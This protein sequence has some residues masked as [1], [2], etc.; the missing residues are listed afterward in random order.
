[1][2]ASGCFALLLVLVVL[3]GS[4]ETRAQFLDPQFGWATG[5]DSSY[6]D[7]HLSLFVTYRSFLIFSAGNAYDQS[8]YLYI[9]DTRS[10]GAPPTVRNYAFPNAANRSMTVLNDQ[11]YIWGGQNA[12][13]SSSS[14]VYVV[15]LSPTYGFPLT[16]YDYDTI[17]PDAFF[18]E[19]PEAHVMAAWPEAQRLYFYG[20]FTSS[21]ASSIGAAVP[22]F[23]LS[24]ASEEE[25]S[26]GWQPVSSAQ[27]YGPPALKHHSGCVRRTRE[28]TLLWYIFGGAVWSVE[29][30]MQ[31]PLDDLWVLNFATE[32]WTQVFKTGAETAWPAAR[33]MHAAV[34]SPDNLHM[35]VHGGRDVSQ[36]FGDL[37]GFD[38]DTESWTYIS[39]AY[40]T[41]GHHLAATIQEPY[42]G[43]SFVQLHLFYPD[44]S[45]AAIY[46][47]SGVT[48]YSCDDAVV[49]PEDD[50]NNNGLGDFCE[51]NMYLS[52][53]D[54]NYN[55]ILDACELD[56]TSTD[57]DHNGMLDE[58]QPFQVI[59][60]RG[61]SDSREVED[62]S[63]KPLLIIVFAVCI[64]VFGLAAAVIGG[65]ILWAQLRPS[66]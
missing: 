17:T 50:C 62:S 12:Y 11:L 34:T 24:L 46:S 16:S 54:C 7:W 27:S 31:T 64:S 39:Q 9:Y 49:T 40:Y 51:I 29:N 48:T 21:V 25:K 22:L 15:P 1:M 20:G 66:A 57:C 26:R 61:G 53:S 6:V 2:S 44:A 38:F 58:C 59:C 45:P 47:S 37:W 56:P 41:Y 28:G 8:T 35:F 30:L 55:D 18:L 36:T 5:V 32:T 23:R 60:S 19:S 4:V 10:V 43:F 3:A 33:H 42:M 52:G 65:F 13:T 63:L 14:S